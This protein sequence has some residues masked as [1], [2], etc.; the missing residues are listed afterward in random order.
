MKHK[1]KISITILAVAFVLNLLPMIS[2]SALSFEMGKSGMGNK[3]SVGSTHIGVIKADGSLWEWRIDQ[4]YRFLNDPTTS[5]NIPTKVMDDAVSIANGGSHT[6]AIKSDGTLWTW[7]SNYRSQLGNGSDRDSN[8]PVKVLDDAVA[9]SASGHTAAIKS[10]GTLWTWGWNK[11]GQLGNGTTMTSGLPIKVLDDV[12]A[13]SAGMCHTAAIKRDGTLWMWG[14]N[15]CGQLGDGSTNNSLLP[16]KV[17]DGVIFVSAG[18]YH[19]AAISKDGNL[20][21]WGANGDGQLGDGSTAPYSLVP[22]NVMSDVVSVSAGV[23]T[24]AAIKSDG[25]LWTW[26]NNEYGQLGNNTFASST[27]PTKVMDNVI[28]VSAGYYDMAA[29]TDNGT[30]WMWGDQNH[31]FSTVPVNLID[32]LSISEEFS[33]GRTETQD[34]YIWETI[35]QNDYKTILLND[36]TNEKQRFSYSVPSFGATILVFF[37]AE[38]CE[39]SVYVFQSISNSNWVNNPNIDIVAVET[40]GASKETVQA[41]ADMYLGNA[42]KYFNIF[43]YPFPASNPPQDSPYYLQFKYSKYLTGET[44]VEWPLAVFLTDDGSGPVVYGYEMG[45]ADASIYGNSLSGLLDSVAYDETV[46]YTLSGTQY[47]N[48]ASEVVRSVNTYRS[49]NGLSSLSWNKTLTEYAM[50][51]AAELAIY[52]DHIRPNGRPYN[53]VIGSDYITDAWFGE[54]IAFGYADSSS[55]M[56]GWMNSPGHRANI[57]N[58]NYTQIGVGCF[59]YEG[60]RYWVQLFGQSSTNTAVINSSEVK[61]VAVTVSTLKSHLEKSATGV[62]ELSLISSVPA[63]GAQNIEDNTFSLTFSS[64]IN[65]NFNWSAGAITVR[66]YRTDQVV[67]TID[68]N[69]FYELGGYVVGDTLTIPA[70]FMELPGGRYYITVDQGLILSATTNSSGSVSKY[71]G[72]TNKTDLAFS[73]AERFTAITFAGKSMNINWDWNYFSGNATAKDFQQDLAIAA[74]ALS[75]E[76]EDYSPDRVV[77]TL[78]NLG[79]EKCDW[80]NYYQDWNY[81]SP[82]IAIGSAEKVIDGSK[83]IIIAVVARG[84]TNAA[85]AFTDLTSVVDGFSIGSYKAKLFLDEYIAKNY[86]GLQKDDLI[87]FI[88]G[89]SL[90]GSTAGVLST[91]VNAVAYRESTFVYTFA[92]PN[93]FGGSVNG[94][95][96]LGIDYPN[97]INIINSG[98][99]VPMVP[100]GKKVGRKIYFSSTYTKNADFVESFYRFTG[101]RYDSWKIT[102]KHSVQCYMSYLLTCLPS[103]PLDVYFTVASVHCPV[104]VDVYDSAG[105]LVASVINNAVNYATDPEVLILVDGDEK[106]IYMPTD[107][108]YDIKLTG[109]DLGSMEYIVQNV[110]STVGEAVIEKTFSDVP[111]SAGSHMSSSIGSKSI[112]SDTKLIIDA[113]NTSASSEIIGTVSSNSPFT[114]VSTSNYYYTPVLW[115]LINGITNGTSDTT[116]SPT[117][118]CSRAQVVTFLWRAAGCPEPANS[119]NTFSDV[120]PGTWYSDAV[121]WAVEQGITNGTSTTTFSPTNTCSRSEIITFLWRADGKPNETGAGTWYDDAVNWANSKGIL[122]GTS[123]TFLPNTPCPRSDI[124]VYMYRQLAA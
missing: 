87:L 58:S 111:I 44:R 91:M 57:L 60:V 45:M 119:Y 51:R 3:I 42:Q 17:M 7:G 71:V 21:V 120:A 19:T 89:H 114:D 20:W 16:K 11:D 102:D 95:D 33:S 27:L 117:M 4:N 49:Q 53:S 92:S 13:V 109:T 103:K 30:L 76:A 116:F 73:I 56:D 55:V 39:N 113:T 90:G 75:A 85:D 67:L 107:G 29:E 41:F 32:G 88:T 12:A 47:Y 108:D 24:T 54:N 52:Y 74:L 97:V 110:D 80:I 70:A 68:I 40:T 123:E 65:H 5:K 112:A 50:Q 28:E 10:D 8:V 26:G 98:D 100:E 23:S 69:K 61:Q 84:T 99:V 36:L 6:A 124:V 15:N 9:V 81:L 66:D 106:Y 77:M 46:D 38:S 101:S 43:Y 35:Q 86:P 34:T 18:S 83:K 2:T 121:L 93:Y 96:I 62:G 79:F 122:A 1:K 78:K 14:N 115:A 72:L 94:S 64:D 59:E 22:Q 25:S 118:T 82:G 37:R 104:D 31:N 48:H 63:N 105:T